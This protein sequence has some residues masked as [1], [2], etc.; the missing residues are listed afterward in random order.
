MGVVCGWLS[1]LVILEMSFHINACSLLHSSCL[2]NAR[3][4]GA[5][6]STALKLS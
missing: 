1:Y 6:C 2:L 4:D 3:P 5:V